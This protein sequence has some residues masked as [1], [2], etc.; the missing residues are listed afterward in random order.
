MKIIVLFF[1]IISYFFII[2]NIKCKM[3]LKIS[4]PIQNV[5]SLNDNEDNEEHWHPLYPKKIKQNKEKISDN[6]QYLSFV[7]LDNNFLQ[8]NKSPCQCRF[9]LDKTAPTQIETKIENKNEETS[10][11]KEIDNYRMKQIEKNDNLNKINNNFPSLYSNSNIMPQHGYPNNP[12]ISPYYNSFY[13][14]INSNLLL[15]NP[16][17]Y[18]Y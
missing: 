4:F 18:L 13:N 16:Y 15:Y 12:F 7:Q 9:I 11:K 3:R 1:C 8:D 10:I 6:N 14:Y 5:P 2:K 17:Y